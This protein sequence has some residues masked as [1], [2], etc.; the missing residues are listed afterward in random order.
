MRMAGATRKATSTYD[1]VAT[2]TFSDTLPNAM[3]S[4][5]TNS[6]WANGYASGLAV[7]NIS[8]P[9]RTISF[10]IGGAAPAGVTYTG[11][12]AAGAEAIHPSPWFE[13]AGGTI[14]ASLT[15]PST[16]DFDLRIERWTGTA[17]VTA[18]ESAGPTST[19]AV[20]YNA[21]AGYYRIIVNSYSGAGSYK[22]VVSK[23]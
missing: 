2:R 23:A 19:E 17:W 18:V 5:G 1:G 22:L 16:A 12:L 9:A 3:N 13:Y 6:K 7:T 10:D 15:G 20:S 4:R 11:S 14:K 8:A 21:P